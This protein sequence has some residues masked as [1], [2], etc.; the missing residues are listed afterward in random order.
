MKK[1][2]ISI[3]LGLIMTSCG[4]SSS[5][6]D[7]MPTPP[8]PV[9][10]DVKVTDN[11]LVSYFNLDKTKYV[12]QAIELLTAQT[13]AKTVNAKNIEVLSTSNSRAQ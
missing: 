13:G 9:V 8:M 2:W 10:E 6:N 4:G 11:D 3:V 1:I 7:P 12:Y 5:S